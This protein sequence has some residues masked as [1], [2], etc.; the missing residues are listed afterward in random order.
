M[1]ALDLSTWYKSKGFEGREDKKIYLALVQCCMKPCPPQLFQV[2][3]R[4]PYGSALLKFFLFPGSLE[5]W[6]IS[7]EMCFIQC[8]RHHKCGA[9]EEEAY[10]S[11]TLSEKRLENRFVFNFF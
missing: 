8:F 6:Y 2:P 11:C 7:A 4:V 10:A 9:L 3:K 5:A 1:N